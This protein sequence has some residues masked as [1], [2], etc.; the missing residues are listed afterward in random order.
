MTPHAKGEPPTGRPQP[1]VRTLEDKAHLVTGSGFWQAGL[2]D[3]P[4]VI[5][6]DGPHGLRKQGAESDH[7]GAARSVPATCFPPAAALGS[8]FDTA[9]AERVGQALGTEAA[10]QDVAVL[11][12]PGMNI[13]RSPL[14]GRNFE[15]FSEDPQHTAALAGAMVRGIQ[16]TGTSACLK[17]FAANNQEYDRMR[18]SAEVDER[19]LREIYLRAFEDVVRFTQ[20]EWV[21]SS[22]NKINGVYAS[23]NHWLLTE[24]L[25]DEWGFEGLVVSDWYAVADR[26]EALKAG[27]DLEMPTTGDRSP[28]RVIAAVANGELDEE[29]LNRCAARLENYLSSRPTGRGFQFGELQQIEHH[30]LAKEAALKSVVL[31]K[32]EDHALPLEASASVAVIGEFARSP[33]YQGAGSSRVNPTVVD[34]ALAHIEEI[35]TGLVSFAPGF[36]T[37]AEPD[38]P[39]LLAEAVETAAQADAVVVFLGL[40]EAAE[41]EGYDREHLNLPERQ[42]R[43]LQAV[44]EVHSRVVVVL[45]AGGVVTLPFYADVAAIL[46]GG[47][48]GQAGGSATADLLFGKQSHSGRLTETIP[49]RLEDVPSYLHFP[50][51]QGRVSYGEGLYVGYRGFDAQKTDVLLPFGHGL[52]YTSFDYTSLE[53][54]ETDTGVEVKVQVTN[55]G[56]RQGREVVQVYVGKPDSS[57]ARAPQELKGFASVELEPG[58]TTTAVVDVRR[59]ELAYWNIARHGW[60]IESG[61]YVVKVGAS[62]RDIR[63]Q[64]QLWIEGENAIGPLTGESTLGDA[65]AHPAVGDDVHNNLMVSA[66]NKHSSSLFSAEGLIRMMSSFPLNRLP[67]FP[68]SGM[69]DDDV[70]SIIART[71]PSGTPNPQPKTQ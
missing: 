23:E 60:V 70:E 49:H 52:S 3:G 62:S 44:R 56:P 59:Q 1:P 67:L 43:V 9:L 37:S 10:A 63:V 4:Q 19:T 38:G 29:I 24:V 26:V 27:L 61:T 7:L 14:C 5:L 32:N 58:E 55:T 30:Q 16:S 50:G 33:R 39:E 42:L 51:D 45:S 15:Y 68:K 57:V 6:T 8:S 54:A 2:P 53:V 65:L 18:V 41:S 17:H 64:R 21:M 28:D 35:C 46:D 47:L 66:N 40:P 31:L 22:Y 13:K 34:P 69:T 25:R 12:G 36:T 20:P 71:Q 11:L 48:L